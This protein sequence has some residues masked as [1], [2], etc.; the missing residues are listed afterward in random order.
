MFGSKKGHDRA[1]PV[2]ETTFDEEAGAGQHRSDRQIGEERRRIGLE[3]PEGRGGDLLGAPGDLGHGDD[4]DQRGVLDQ[5]QGLTDQCRQH[6]AEGLR[7][8]DA[9]QDLPAGETEEA[10]RLDLAL[11]DRLQP[12]PVEISAWKAAVLRA[13]ATTAAMAGAKATPSDE[14]R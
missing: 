10:G 6:H 14:G 5:R 3:R 13:S 7:R 9:E 1:S 12:G 8:F 4:R 2:G 11:R